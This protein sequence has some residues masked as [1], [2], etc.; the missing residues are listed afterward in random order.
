MEQ[1]LKFGK[2]EESFVYPAMEPEI[3]MAIKRRLSFRIVRYI[4]ISSF[5]AIFHSNCQ[6]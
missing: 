1:I 6:E 4:K 5:F 2:E 3:A